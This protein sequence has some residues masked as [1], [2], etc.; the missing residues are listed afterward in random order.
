M[1]F[2][3]V[4]LDVQ[5]K[6]SRTAVTEVNQR[7]LFEVLVY[8]ACRDPFISAELR[9]WSQIFVGPYCFIYVKTQN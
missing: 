6:G 1:R 3:L 8:V 7:D 9:E 4:N 2:R 5:L